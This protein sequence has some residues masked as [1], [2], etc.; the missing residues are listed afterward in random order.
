MTYEQAYDPTI[1]WGANPKRG[2]G[3]S[4][5]KSF[6]AKG[7]QPATSSFSELFHRKFIFKKKK[8]K[9]QIHCEHDSVVKCTFSDAL[10]QSSIPESFSF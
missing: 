6:A 7:Q 10:D 9:Q 8:K 2:R 4:Q 5:A 1:R 3:P